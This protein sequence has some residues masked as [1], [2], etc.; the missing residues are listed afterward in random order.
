MTAVLELQL[1]CANKILFFFYTR[2]LYFYK[3]IALD[4]LAQC[5]PV[6]LCWVKAHVGTQ[7]NEEA[8]RLAKLASEQLVMGPEPMLPVP[9]SIILGAN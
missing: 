7:G 4:D 2:T 1:Q 6:R 8:D 5:G 3:Q 9:N